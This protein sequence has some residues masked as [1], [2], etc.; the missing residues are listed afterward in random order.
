VGSHPFACLF[1]PETTQ[2]RLKRILGKLSHVSGWRKKSIATANINLDQ[3]LPLLHLQFR[4]KYLTLEWC[5][6]GNSF[7]I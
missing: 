4:T 7:Q 5:T 1:L 2:I 6:N 3:Y